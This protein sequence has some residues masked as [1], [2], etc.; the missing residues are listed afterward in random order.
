MGVCV[1][2]EGDCTVGLRDSKWEHFGH[3]GK[4]DTKL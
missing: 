4:R 2:R 1:W 3:R